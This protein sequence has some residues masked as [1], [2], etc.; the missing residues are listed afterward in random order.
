MALYYMRVSICNGASFIVCV[1]WCNCFV[2]V[3]EF[4]VRLVDVDVWDCSVYDVLTLI[5]QIGRVD[6]E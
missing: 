5:K 3:W 2:S 1:A 6:D 4:F